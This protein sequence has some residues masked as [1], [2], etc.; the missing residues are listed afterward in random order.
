[1]F[2]MM[3]RLSDNIC[4]ACRNIFVKDAIPQLYIDMSWDE[5]GHVIPSQDKRSILWNQ[6]AEQVASNIASGCTMC[7]T[8]RHYFQTRFL[9]SK[10]YDTTGDIKINIIISYLRITNFMLGIYPLEE[11][12]EAGEG[13]LSYKLAPRSGKTHISPTKAPE[14]F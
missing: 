2:S 10:L 6:T 14:C 4:T 9:K 13:W 1:V 12:G 8:L 3:S 11:N 5:P 7:E